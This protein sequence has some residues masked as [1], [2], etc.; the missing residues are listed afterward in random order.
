MKQDRSRR[1]H[2][3]VLDAAAT[4]FAAHGFA[5]TNLQ[6]VAK[7]TGL[8]KGAVYGHFS[9]KEALADELVRLFEESWGDLLC[10]AERCGQGPEEGLRALV[11]GLTRHVQ[12][13]VRFTAGLRLAAEDA[14]ALGKTPAFVGGLGATISRL[15]RDAQECGVVDP[16]L[17]AEPLGRLLLAL[18]LGMHQITSAGGADPTHQQVLAVGDL[19][20]LLIR[21]ATS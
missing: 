17:D 13:D 8:T 3:L 5:R 15:V 1:T 2:A 16:A 20:L 10:S 14:R 6:I 21:P 7:H 18:V 12:E 4:E 9:S 11:L 19:I